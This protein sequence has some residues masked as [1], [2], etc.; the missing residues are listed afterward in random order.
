ISAVLKPV[1][2]SLRGMLGQ[3]PPPYNKMATDMLDTPFGLGIFVAVIIAVLV[4]LIVTVRALRNR[5]PKVKKAPKIIIGSNEHSA[6][7]QAETTRITVQKESLGERLKK[8]FA[9][10]TGMLE[11][12]PKALAAPAEEEAEETLVQYEAEAAEEELAAAAQEAAVEAKS[13][14]KAQK[15]AAAAMDHSETVMLKAPPKAAPAPAPAAAEP[16]EEVSDDTTAEA[17]VY[18]AY[19]LFDQA[20]ELLKQG[21]ANNP[22]AV[23]YRGKLLETYFAAGKKDEFERLAADLRK[24]TGNKPS[25]IWD[26]AVAMGKEIA[27]DNPLFSGADTAL[28]VSDFAPAKLETADLDLGEAGGATTP[29]VDFGEDAATASALDLDISNSFDKTMVSL[30]STMIVDET[31]LEPASKDVTDSELNI[32]FDADELGLGGELETDDSTIIAEPEATMAIDIGF[33]VDNVD[34]ITDVDGG[35]AASGTFD[36]KPSAGDDLIAELSSDD[37]ELNLEAASVDTEFDLPEEDDTIIDAGDDT[38]SGDSASD[39]DEVSTKLDLAKAYM[40]MGDYDGAS[41]TLE[42]VL[43]EGSDKQKREAEELLDQIN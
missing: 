8:A 28:K 37:S 9:P 12:K 31:S 1:Q 14:T 43:A 16:Q 19:G 36:A 22:D 11:R 40:D 34:G 3:L 4:L 39:A 17:D 15:P 30:D 6:G 38:F 10:F 21:L 41:S 2:D 18:L 42:E 29:D 27:P 32:N 23:H 35:L 5:P 33:D 25:R 13:K 26:K 24:S 7:I 20:E